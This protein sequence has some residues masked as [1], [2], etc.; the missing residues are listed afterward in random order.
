MNL[1]HLSIIA[2]TA[3]LTFS[4]S[5]LFA[6]DTSPPIESK[7]VVVAVNS[8]L[9]KED[10]DLQRLFNHSSNPAVRLTFMVKAKNIVQ[11]LEKSVV[12]NHSKEWKCGSH[13]R[14]ANE[15]EAAAFIIEKKGDFI[16]KENDIK[17]TGTIDIQ[18]GTKLVPKSFSLMS[19]DEPFRMDDFVFTLLEDKLKVEGNHKLIKEITVKHN[20]KIL[21]T[22]GASWSNDTKTYNYKD[23]GKGAKI[24]FSYW[25]G[26]VTRKVKFSKN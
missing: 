4:P 11:V 6:E 21:N 2:S 7:L 10:N 1:K 22:H 24:S 26:L 15:G 25:D 14:I 9:A 3:L 17:V 12:T 18:T 16:G 8:G 19:Y 5:C 23:I 13:P 20:D